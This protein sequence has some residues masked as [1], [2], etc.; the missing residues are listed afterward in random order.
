MKENTPINTWNRYLKSRKC[1]FCGR[2]EK[3]LIVFLIN[4]K[5]TYMCQHCEKIFDYMRN[6]YSLDDLRIYINT[7]H[8]Q[9]ETIIPINKLNIKMGD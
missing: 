1:V 6:I 3:Q 4:D 9:A 2:T 7:L 8:G 5:S